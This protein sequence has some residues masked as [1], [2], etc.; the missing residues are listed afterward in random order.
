MPHTPFMDSELFMYVVLPLLIFI[1]RIFD[2]SVGIMRIIFATKGLR[3][4]AL[5]VGFFESFIWLLAI[6]QIMKHLD[7]FV[8]YFA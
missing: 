1:A 3:H 5:L 8:C 2:Q 4:L 7:N 6:S